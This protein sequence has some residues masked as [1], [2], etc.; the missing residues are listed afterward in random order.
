MRKTILLTLSVLISGSVMAD[1]KEKNTEREEPR[2]VRGAP[3]EISGVAERMKQQFTRMDQDGDGELT[4]EELT[5]MPGANRR[6]SFPQGNERAAAADREARRAERQERMKKRTQDM[7]TKY[8]ADDSSA[9]NVEEFTKTRVE[10]LENMD[11]NKD[12]KVTRE[13]MRA[14]RQAQESF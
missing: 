12:G 8:D 4:L 7:L 9:L 11:T 6:G 3:I 2:V 5:K 10:P 1:D 13:E 14:G